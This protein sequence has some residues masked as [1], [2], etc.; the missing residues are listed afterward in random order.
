MDRRT[1]LLSTGRWLLVAGLAPTVSGCS[2]LLRASDNQNR[3]TEG[4]A[5]STS[6]SGSTSSSAPGTTSPPTTA[7]PTTSPSG[8]SST[9]ATTSTT[10]FVPPDLAVVKGEVVEK[11]VRAAVALLGGMER[12]VKKGGKVVVKP[13]VLNGR[14]PE[15]ATT[16]SPELMAAVIKMCWEAGAK[17]V[18]VLDRPTTDARAAFEV[19]GLA[20]AVSDAGGS[21]LYLSNRNYEAVDIPE[22]KVLTSWPFV[23]DALAADSLINLTLPK[24]HSVSG[25]T[26]TM[27]NLMGIMGGS[28]G[29]IHRDFA[30]KIVDV[31]TLVKPTLA[32][33]DAYRVLFRNGPTGGDLADVKIVKTLVAGTNQVAIDAYG[34]QFFGKTPADYGW[35]VEASKRG[36]G[37][38]DLTKLNIAT[39]EAV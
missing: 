17:E 14:P 24:H 23:T 18:V 8:T 10:A 15:Y 21:L 25:A 29:Q 19:T 9:A 27:K 39:S 5:G 34:T 31:N 33:L 2:R 11:N 20:K 30:Q 6:T 37:E 3:G 38:I 32:I 28:R 16:T 36:M 12:F 13:N 35:L 7:T 22:G 1:F 4:E 26:M